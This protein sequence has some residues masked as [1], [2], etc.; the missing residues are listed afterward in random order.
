MIRTYQETRNIMD[1][2]E[3]LVHKYLPDFEVKLIGAR[4]NV[5][6]RIYLNPKTK[7]IEINRSLV[8]QGSWEEIYD[9]TVHEISHA[10]ESN[11][12]IGTSTTH[13]QEWRDITRALGGSGQQRGVYNAEEYLPRYKFTCATCGFEYTTPNKADP[14]IRNGHGFH[15]VWYVRDIITGNKWSVHT[16]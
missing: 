6:G 7:V 2:V 16:R 11:R 3:N 4:T 15:K 1:K 14:W 5:W 8:E 13:T 9:N 10:L 12:D